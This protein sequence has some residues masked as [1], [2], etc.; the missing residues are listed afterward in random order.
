MKRKSQ[1]VLCSCGDVATR[2]F[3]FVPKDYCEHCYDEIVNGT[4]PQLDSIG[5]GRDRDKGA[6]SD[7]DYH[8]GRFNQGE[9]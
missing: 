4:I 8:G 7:A 1:T 3:G 5:I 6:K 9:W 2:R